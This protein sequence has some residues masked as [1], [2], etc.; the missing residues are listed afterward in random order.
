MLDK[1][2]PKVTADAIA[3]MPGYWAFQLGGW[4]AFALLSILSLNAWYNPGELAPAL[5]SI[6]QSMIGVVVS[7]PMRWVAQ[8]TWTMDTPTR[9]LLNAVGILAASQLWTVLR[10]TAF[11][12][13]TGQSIGAED[14]GGWIFGSLT[15]FASWSF[16][17]HAL[18]FHR[19]WLEQRELSI[20]AESAAHKAEALAQQENIRRLHAESLAR[21]AKLRRLNYQ[22]NPHFFFNALNSVNAL[23]RRKNEKGAMEM[24]ARIGE[25]LRVSLDSDDLFHHPLRDEID[26]IKRYLDIEK[27]RFDD[28]LVTQFEISDAAANVEIP[29]FLLQPL[30]ENSIKHAVGRNLEQSTIGVFAVA[31]D[32]RLILRITDTGPDQAATPQ[33][34]TETQRGIGLK[35]VEE[36]L[37]SVYGERYFLSATSRQDN[38]FEITMSLPAQYPEETERPEAA[39]SSKFDWDTGRAND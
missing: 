10:L 28:R 26:I 12:F 1:F 21:E 2:D 18:K 36:R 15:V 19:Q 37:Q 3:N 6:V 4:S 32:D 20:I 34:S 39:A 24:I 13:M 5:H 7:H 30:V 23:I 22:L 31:E 8:R 17:Y 11:N 33:S 9:L 29:S 14:W 35:N 27:V 38:G 25:F 16:C